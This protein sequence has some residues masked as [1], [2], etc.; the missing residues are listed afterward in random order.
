MKVTGGDGCR[1]SFICKRSILFAPVQLTCTHQLLSGVINYLRGK[2]QGYLQWSISCVIQIPGKRWDASISVSKSI[3]R[4]LRPLSCD[5]CSNGNRDVTTVWKRGGSYWMTP[6]VYWWKRMRC[7]NKSGNR[8]EYINCRE[9]PTW[10]E[11]IRLISFKAQLLEKQQW[12]TSMHLRVVHWIMRVCVWR[13]GGCGRQMK[14]TQSCVY[15][16]SLFQFLFVFH[17]AIS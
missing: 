8:L 1:R 2:W 9:V 12:G 5:T 6:L 17:M 11:P 4:K 15:S 3:S 14:C 7:Q 10:L 16:K 13:G